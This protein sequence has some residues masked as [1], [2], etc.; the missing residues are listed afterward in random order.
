M[1]RKYFKGDYDLMREDFMLVNWEEEFHEM[2][3]EA[4]WQRFCVVMDME[5]GKCVP[6]EAVRQNGYQKWMNS[7]ARRG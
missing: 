4:M 2:D 7:A 1:Q 3:V 5:I 6:S